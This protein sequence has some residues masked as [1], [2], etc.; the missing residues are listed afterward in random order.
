MTQSNNSDPANYWVNTTDQIHGPNNL[1]NVGAQQTHAIQILV[2]VPEDAVNGDAV[3]VTVT[4]QSERA[5]YVLFASTMVMAG[6]TFS[7]EIFQNHSH[8]MGENF[9]NITPGSPRTLH[10]LSL[11][12]I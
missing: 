4:I 12:H 9:A 8:S 11:I 1:L 6:G 2:E 5:G 3:I 10:Y 7:A